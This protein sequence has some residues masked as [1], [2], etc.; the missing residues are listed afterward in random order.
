MNTYRM[1]HIL[2]FSFYDDCGKTFED[3][4]GRK[5]NKHRQ[6]NDLKGSGQTMINKTLNRKLRKDK[7]FRPTSE[8]RRVAL[9]NNVCLI[10][11]TVNSVGLMCT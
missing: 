8:I 6:Y 9:V 4:T 7:Q 5:S 1:V 3:I 2:H 10:V 11:H